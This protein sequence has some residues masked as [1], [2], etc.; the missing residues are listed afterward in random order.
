MSLQQLAHLAGGYC[1]DLFLDIPSL[2]LSVEKWKAKHLML[3]DSDDCALF[4]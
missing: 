1:K 4:W 3:Q 2:F